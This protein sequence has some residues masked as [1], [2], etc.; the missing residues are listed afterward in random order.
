MKTVKQF[1][2]AITI[3][4]LFFI[5]GCTTMQNIP[6]DDVYYSTSNGVPQSLAAQNTNTTAPARNEAVKVE[7]VNMS[8]QNTSSANQNL[9]GYSIDTLRTDTITNG[10]VDSAV[11]SKINT[12]LGFNSP[13][14][15]TGV[16]SW[17]LGG[18]AGA[19]GYNTFGYDPFWD[20]SYFSY[21][22]YPF[23]NNWNSYYFGGFGISAFGYL[24]WG[25][26]FSYPYYGYNPYYGYGYPYYGIA[27][28]YHNRNYGHRGSTLRGSNLPFSRG[29][30]ILYGEKST[31]AGN[32]KP[33]GIRS[34]ATYQNNANETV[35]R[36]VGSMR[37]Q[38]ALNNAKATRA[39]N[40]GARLQKPPVY[41]SGNNTVA[42]ARQ[43]E[44]PAYRRQ[45]NMSAP[46]Y[47]KPKQYQSLDTRQPRSS[48]EYF[49][50]Q[51]QTIINGRAT[52]VNTVRTATRRFN[53]YRPAN[54]R[55]YNSR[56]VYRN[57]WIRTTRSTP[58]RRYSS[59]KFYSSPRYNN[60]NNNTRSYS[61]P[62]R[63]NTGNRGTS[64]GSG[65]RGGGGGGNIRR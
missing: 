50:P 42:P 5:T 51:P 48:N 10:N 26:G 52:R 56:P 55:S 64:T 60:S 63:V 9:Q 36:P 43:Y 22:Y 57:S 3:V 25:L 15:G 11:Y 40:N 6:Y 62:V 53:I 44:K 46:R 65:T 32:V 21:S 31:Q 54:T 45:M 7:A 39:E 1:L 18:Y 59:P 33:S 16:T 58:T 49:R 12:G 61:P 38:K 20:N 35:K 24:Y 23:Y 2:L 30:V 29:S 19:F 13:Y 4:S 34:S 8:G 17:S 37:Y 14:F 28:Y 47:R 41:R 27:S